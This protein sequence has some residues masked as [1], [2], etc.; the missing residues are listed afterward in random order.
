MEFVTTRGRLQFD[1]WDQAGQEKF[2]GQRD[3]NFIQGDCGIIMFDVMSRLSYKDV[4]NWHR[5]LTR[6]CE[7]GARRCWIGLGH[8]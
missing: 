6:V 8:Q 4:P 3:G 2:A 1:V 7:N 5:D